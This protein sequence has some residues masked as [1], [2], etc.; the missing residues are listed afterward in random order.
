MNIRKLHGVDFPLKIKPGLM[1]P[2]AS[3]SVIKLF[4]Q[5]QSASDKQLLALLGSATFD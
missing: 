2:N 4:A 1:T 5:K 3:Q